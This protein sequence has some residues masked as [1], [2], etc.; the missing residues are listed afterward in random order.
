MG[1]ALELALKIPMEDTTPENKTMSYDAVVLVANTCKK[2]I[3]DHRGL[4]VDRICRYNLEAAKAV[5]RHDPQNAINQDVLGG[6]YCLAG[7]NWEGNKWYRKAAAQGRDVKR[8]LILAQM[9]CPG[10]LFEHHYAFPEGR[11]I[12]NRDKKHLRLIPGTDEILLSGHVDLLE[13]TMLEDP[14]DPIV[15]GSIL[16]KLA[17]EEGQIELKFE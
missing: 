8:S 13:C 15:F 14:D 3:I 16:E 2:I 1:K 7:N 10:M 9:H 11:F 17:S 12:H 6:A 4:N 5:I